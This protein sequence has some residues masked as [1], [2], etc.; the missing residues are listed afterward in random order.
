MNIQKLKSEIK[1]QEKSRLARQKIRNL[2]ESLAYIANIP[3]GRHL[4]AIIGNGNETSNI[5]AL[6]T[7]IGNELKHRGLSEVNELDYLYARLQTVLVEWRIA[8][9]NLNFP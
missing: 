9:E 7:W 5:E 1:K 8:S 6:Q 3:N 2:S 4:V